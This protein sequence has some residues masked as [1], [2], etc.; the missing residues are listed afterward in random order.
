MSR[1]IAWA[2]GVAALLAGTA[3]YPC[4][5]PFGNNITV[6]PHQDIIVAWKDGVETYA[7]QPTFCGQ[8]TDF[9][10]ILPVPALLSQNPTVNDQQTFATVVT[11]SEPTKREVSV[12]SGGIGCGGS[13]SA[14]TG[15]ANDDTPAVVASGQVG[16]LD[17]SQIKADN[18]SSLT[19]W[20]SKNGYPYS[21]GASTVFSYYVGKGWYFL[22]FRINQ[23]AVAGGGTICRSLGPIALSF[24]TSVPVVPSA[25][26]SADA[27]TDSSY[28]QVSWRIFGITHGDVQL[29]FSNANSYDKVLWYSGAISDASLASLGGLAATGDR[30]TRLALTFTKSASST[31]VDL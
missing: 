29:T 6:D 4:G 23:Q 22:A 31:D 13:D 28:Q 17:W 10:L 11:L 18:E 14:G 19:E 21:A 5:A 12:S 16:I 25:M 2:C 20:L 9:G 15:G 26:A 8:A 3:A 30:L 1:W 7:F 27:A 24:P